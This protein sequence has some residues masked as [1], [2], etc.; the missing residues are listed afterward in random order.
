MRHHWGDIEEARA[1]IDPERIQP[2]K[3]PPVP[4]RVPSSLARGWLEAKLLGKPEL[5]WRRQ[6]LEPIPPKLRAVLF[7]LVARGEPLARSEIEELF[8]GPKSG[9]SLR[10]A[11]YQLHALP[12]AEGWLSINREVT[13][14]ATS[15]LAAFEAA[16]NGRHYKRALEIWQAAHP[17]AQSRAALLWGFELDHAPAFSDW[18]EV[19]RA[20]IEMLYLEALEH[21]ALELE[22]EEKHAQAL[23]LVQTLLRE[24][25]LNDSAYRAAM[26]LCYRMGRLEEAQLYFE[27]CRRILLEE[28]GVE[29]PI[30]TVTLALNLRM[31]NG[32]LQPRTPTLRQVLHQLP[33][34]RS[35]NGQRY[36]LVPLMSL[37]LLASLSGAHSLRDIA[38]FGRDHPDLLHKLGFHRQTPPGRSTLCEFLRRLDL[39]QLR[40]VLSSVAPLPSAAKH[41]GGSKEANALGLIEA[42]ALELRYRLE[43]AEAGWLTAALERLGWSGLLVW[44]WV[45]TELG[46]LGPPM[47]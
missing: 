19:E 27:H 39:P 28:L 24:D 32:L 9:H 11:L 35:R 26:R 5:R 22:E 15:D 41:E 43:F 14:K 1:Q 17:P 18:L 4:P 36:E 45:W 38:R 29:P 3:P 30:E 34:P 31:A 21:R 12:G 10:Q 40:H 42:W 47:P 7:Y 44:V 6:L 20:R 37:V 33:D 13:V 8:W 16:V 25:P 46:L 2:P 23:A